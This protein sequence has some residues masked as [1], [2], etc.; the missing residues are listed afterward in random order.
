[1][2]GNIEMSIAYII[3]NLNIVIYRNDNNNDQHYNHYANIWNENNHENT[4][5]LILFLG[6]NHYS[7][8]KYC[9]KE[10]INNKQST[11]VDNLNIE[12]NILQIDKE[13]L[14]NNNKL[15]INYVV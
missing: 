7:L 6:N 14:I 8:L 12:F 15:I 3:F 2:A 1:M 9:N 5:L 4:F 13:Y 10:S 11:I